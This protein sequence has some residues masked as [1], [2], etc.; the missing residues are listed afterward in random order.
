M[1]KAINYRKTR[2]LQICIVFATALL[3]QRLLGYTH[4]GW[5]GFAVMM[6]YAGF[7]KGP[8]LQRTTYRFWGALC[9]LFLSYILWF[10]GQVN[11][12]FI[13]III[14]LIVYMAY[15]TL[16]KSYAF[17]TV[18]TV[19]LTA[20]GT[21]YYAGN[22]YAVPNFFF[23]YLLSTVVALL[24]CFTFEYWIFRGDDLSRK[25]FIDIQKTVLFY[26]EELFNIVLRQTPLN[27]SH[28]LKT[29]THFNEKVMEL[30]TF[31]TITKHDDREEIDFIK[32]LELFN[33]I[34]HQAYHNI[35]KLFVLAP[36]KN[37][38]LILETKNI[39]EQLRKVN[40]NQRIKHIGE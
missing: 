4:A 40:Q 18:F 13:L 35:R 12:R 37:E 19:T 2:A 8:S 3:I 32:E 25:F 33:S 15:F 16:G 28:Y 17:P 21:D 29:S 36:V 34:V 14:P 38:L 11:F 22:S 31:V 39:L 30:Y 20:L 27:Q 6:I 10:L 9:G 1:F 23:D 5:I 7:E 26:L 24:I